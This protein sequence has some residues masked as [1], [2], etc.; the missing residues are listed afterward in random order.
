MQLRARGVE[1]RIGFFLHIPFPPPGVLLAVP[2]H[3]WL[4]KALF[5]FDVVGFQ[6]NADVINFQ[7]FVSEQS[8]GEVLSDGRII[9]IGRTVIA[10]AFPIGIDA[11]AFSAM[12]RT[13]A[14][15]EVIERLH[16]RLLARS[17]I[18]GVDR[19]DYT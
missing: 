6:T 11:D 17:H 16:R 19:L 1:Q 12:S 9:A 18:I 2:V 7:R 4:V 5:S 13:P 10:R 3:N 14:A 15:Q 8:E